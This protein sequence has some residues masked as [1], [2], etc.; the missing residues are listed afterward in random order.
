VLRLSFDD[1]LP[2]LAGLHTAEED[3][4]Y[5]RTRLFRESEM[6]GAFDG[7]LIAFIAFAGG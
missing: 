1:R 2:S 3:L 6:W 7:Q 4:E 5:F